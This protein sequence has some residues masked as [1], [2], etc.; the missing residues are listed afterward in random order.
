MSPHEP[1]DG[2]D[3]EDLALALEKFTGIF[4]RLASVEKM[5]FTTLGVLHTL[6]GRGPLRLSELK[7]SEQVTQPAITQLVTRL[8][9]DGLVRRRPDPTD[10]R[11]VL[12]H[13]TPAGAQVVDKRRRDRVDRLTALTRRLSTPQRQAVAAALPALLEMAE[14]GAQVLD[15]PPASSPPR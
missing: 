7:A 5:S 2:L 3:T 14:L 15:E 4:I 10:G 9:R 11:A 8:E 6:A 12:V 1:P 13:L